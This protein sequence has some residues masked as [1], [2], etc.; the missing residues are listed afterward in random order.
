MFL[1]QLADG[2]STTCGPPACTYA[3]DTTLLFP[4]NLN[5][6]RPLITSPSRIVAACTPSIFFFFFYSHSFIAYLSLSRL[7]YRIN[8]PCLAL[9]KGMQPRPLFPSLSCVHFLFLFFSVQSV[10]ERRCMLSTDD[11]AHNLYVSLSHR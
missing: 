8:T 3:L 7:L 5:T 1:F 6:E 11:T 10:L 4:S 2:Q 9:L